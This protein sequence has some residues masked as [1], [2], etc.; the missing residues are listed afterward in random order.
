M[1]GTSW[2]PLLLLAVLQRSA[3][4]R[5]ARAVVQGL[6]ESVVERQWRR[7]AGSMPASAL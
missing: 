4:R 7:S 3:Y 2:G 5:T 1:S 6:V